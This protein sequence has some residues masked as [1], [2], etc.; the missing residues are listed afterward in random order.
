MKNHLAHVNP[1]K[2]IRF[3]EKVLLE[4]Q[5]EMRGLLVGNVEKKKKKQ[6]LASTIRKTVN[7]NVGVDESDE[8]E[9]YEAQL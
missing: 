7:K 6:S 2:S 8:E 3:C 5:A 9:N 1:T 4:V